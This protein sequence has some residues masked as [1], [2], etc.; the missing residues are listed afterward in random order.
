MRE[1]FRS[2]KRKVGVAT[3][4]MAGLFAVGWVR[5]QIT[6]DWVA[7]VSCGKIYLAESI[8]GNVLLKRAFDPPPLEEPLVWWGSGYL[9]DIR[10]MDGEGS[11]DYLIVCIPNWSTVMPLT[12]LP[13][14]LLLSRDR[15]RLTISDDTPPHPP[16]QP[17]QR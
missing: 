16:K 9:I 12:L 5:G 14:Y 13:A 8:D 11:Y 2:W 17:D 15:S 4:V 6:N 1:F 7:V 3:L 10:P